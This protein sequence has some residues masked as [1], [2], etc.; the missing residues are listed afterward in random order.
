MGTVN[1]TVCLGKVGLEGGCEL[2]GRLKARSWRSL[3]AVLKTEFESSNDNDDDDDG[4]RK[5]SQDS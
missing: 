2:G 4:D 1:I 5:H 3:C